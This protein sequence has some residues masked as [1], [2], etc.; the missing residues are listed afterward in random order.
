MSKGVAV[1][2]VVVPGVVVLAPIMICYYLLD[3]Y[4]YHFRNWGDELAE[5]RIEVSHC[6]NGYIQWTLPRGHLK[7]IKLFI[8]DRSFVLGFK[9]L[10]FM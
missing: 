3:M 10:N 1:L 9:S 5:L 4:I 2:R 8:Y 7:V 6:D